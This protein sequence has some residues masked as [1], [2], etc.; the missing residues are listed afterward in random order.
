MTRHTV[1]R[2]VALT[3]CL[4]T[5]GT[6][7]LSTATASADQPITLVER[8]QAAAQVPTG[9]DWQARGFPAKQPTIRG[10]FTGPGNYIVNGYPNGDIEIMRAG[11]NAPASVQDYPKVGPYMDAR[12]RDTANGHPQ[13]CVEA[14]APEQA[15]H[16]VETVTVYW[17]DPDFRLYW[18]ASGAH[19]PTD[20]RRHDYCDDDRWPGPY[21]LDVKQGT[22][23]NTCYHFFTSINEDMLVD[24]WI[25]YMDD[26]AFGGSG[27]TP[28]G[29]CWGEAEKNVRFTSRA[30]GRAIGLLIHD[31]DGSPSV[32]ANPAYIWPSEYDHRTLQWYN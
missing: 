8:K 19:H 23:T 18:G 5:L 3:T 14:W 4:I 27:Q 26:Y 22:Q 29:L 9:W 6:I 15:F 17:S 16:P 30:M 21:R 11:G 2:I 1:H 20:T 32:M 13:L 24:R 12:W 28:A 25:V 31:G 10:G 7:S